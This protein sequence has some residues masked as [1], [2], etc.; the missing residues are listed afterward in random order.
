[1]SDEEDL[2]PIC[3]ES[4]QSGTATHALEECGHQFHTTCILRWF[5]QEEQHN[6]C[7]TCRHVPDHTPLF[8]NPYLMRTRASSLRIYARRKDAPWE[9]KRLVK[10]LKTVESKSAAAT[11]TFR[12]FAQTHK[13]VINKYRS[14]RRKK[15]DQVWNCRRHKRELAAYNRLI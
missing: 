1:M 4:L 12:E 5:R 15:F 6:E 10:R 11:K 2:C 9:L 3:Y 13:S 7:P 8:Q 14:L